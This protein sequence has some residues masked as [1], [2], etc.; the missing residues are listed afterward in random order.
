MKNWNNGI[1]ELWDDGMMKLFINPCSSGRRAFSHYSIHP[2]I[3]YSIY[4]YYF[5]VSLWRMVLTG[6]NDAIQ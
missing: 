5:F 1:M 4:P 6:E 2:L 3:H